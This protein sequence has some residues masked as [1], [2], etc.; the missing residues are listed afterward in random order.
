MSK[1]STNKT[2]LVTGGAGYIGSHTVLALLESGFKVV[3]LDKAPLH[4]VF[5]EAL[6]PVCENVYYEQ[7]DLLDL[8]HLKVIFGM[9]QFDGVIHFA[10]DP[11]IVS[12]LPEHASQYYTQN[13]V[14]SINLVDMCREYGVN[15]FVFSST[16][17]M[18]GI[19]E[20]LPISEDSKLQPINIYGYTK[21]VIERM[22]H[23]YSQ[24]FGLNSIALR[25]FNACGADSQ[26]RTGECHFPEIHLIPNILQSIGTDKVFELYGNDYN[27]PDGT[28][29]RDYIHVTDLASGHVKALEYLF[30]NEEKNRAVILSKGEVGSGFPN[31]ASPRQAKDPMEVVSN[32]N[33]SA[34]N[35]TTICQAINLGT[36]SGYSNKQI[37]DTAQKIVG[38][39]IPLKIVG[40]RGNGDPDELVADNTKAKQV[41]G[42]E[43]TNSSLE[44]ILR[45]AW[46]WENVKKDL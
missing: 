21:S 1:S 38:Q 10:A 32:S 43:P 7:A 19:P 2:I 37:F 4:K 15:N 34:T 9:F 20:T 30:K 6:R 29:V 11:A 45:T 31:E 12:P 28:N 40:R 39:E 25:Y 16:A 35:K 8:D 36:G 42:W 24:V 14:S 26:M 23:D 18:Y 5:S 44:N 17:A 13:V 27:T 33:N 46:D 22:L 3:I 41:L